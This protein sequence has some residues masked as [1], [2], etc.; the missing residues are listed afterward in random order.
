MGDLRR[1]TTFMNTR[2]FEA[3]ALFFGFAALASAIYLTGYIEGIKSGAQA[4]RDG[5][6]AAFE[7]IRGGK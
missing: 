2:W 6:H 4:S 5:I 1:W 7:A 3:S